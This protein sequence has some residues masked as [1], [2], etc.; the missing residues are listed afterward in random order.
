MTHL[1]GKHVCS[2]SVWTG[3]ILLVILKGVWVLKGVL[4]SAK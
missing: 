2:K 3:G 4:G 1:K